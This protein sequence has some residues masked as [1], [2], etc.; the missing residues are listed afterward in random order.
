MLRRIS[1]GKMNNLRDL[2]LPRRRRRYRLGAFFA[3]R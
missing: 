1:L 2:G 3:G